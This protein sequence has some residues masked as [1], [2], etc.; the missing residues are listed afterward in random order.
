M[1]NDHDK[2]DLNNDKDNDNRYDNGH[3]CDGDDE[4]MIMFIRQNQIYIFITDRRRMLMLF[5][6]NVVQDLVH[7][8]S[9]GRLSE[10]C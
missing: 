5:S 9:T 10:D 2:K 4:Y 6:P 8:F 1:N 3:V 7:C